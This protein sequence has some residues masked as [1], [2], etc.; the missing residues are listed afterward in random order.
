[1]SGHTPGPWSVYLEGPFTLGGD[2]VAVEALT[3]DGM[4]ERTVCTLLVDTDDFPN[5]PEWLEDAANARLIAAAPVLLEACKA[6]W[7]LLDAWDCADE[8]E[9]EDGHKM[10]IALQAAIDKAGAAP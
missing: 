5:G 9:D 4:V 6:A 10:L 3:P 8:P 7:E 1:M 2:T